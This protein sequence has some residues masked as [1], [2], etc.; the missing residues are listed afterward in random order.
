MFTTADSDTPRK[1]IPPN[2]QP[3]ASIMPEPSPAAVPVLPLASSVTST[4]TPLYTSDAQVDV[5]NVPPVQESMV[6]DVAVKAPAIEVQP[7][8][9]AVPESYKKE[10]ATAA[11]SAAEKSVGAPSVIVNYDVLG[12]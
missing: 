1:G 10:S 7:L 4:T 3:I 9:D 2:V 6:S 8:Q 11:P 5:Q 12:R